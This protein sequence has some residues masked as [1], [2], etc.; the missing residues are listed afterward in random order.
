MCLPVI[1]TVADGFMVWPSSIEERNTLSTSDPKLSAVR[2]F[3]PPRVLTIYIY[4]VGVVWIILFSIIRFCTIARCRSRA[5]SCSRARLDPAVGVPA[6]KW[7][8]CGSLTAFLPI[9]YTAV[10]GRL[11]LHYPV[12]FEHLM[13]FSLRLCFLAAVSFFFTP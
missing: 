3:S 7:H 9:N 13:R 10:P 2:Y 5:L 1:P 6:S 8:N 11:L 4:G 12:P